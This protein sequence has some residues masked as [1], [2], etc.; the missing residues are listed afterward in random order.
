MKQILKY[1]LLLLF[2]ISNNLHSQFANNSYHDDNMMIFGFDKFANIITFTGDLDYLLN[3]KYG[4]IFLNQDY[5]GTSITNANSFRDDESLSFFYYYPIFSNLFANYELNWR[6][7][8]DTRSI[9]FN[10]LQRLNSLAGITYK[11]IPE[12]NLSALAGAESNTQ[13]GVNSNGIV[14]K[15][16]AEI[17]QYSFDNYQFNSKFAGEYLKLDDKRN[18][19]DIAF[20]FTAFR[21]FDITDNIAIDFNYKFLSRDFLI[22]N[23]SDINDFLVENRMET[24]IGGLFDISYKISDRLVAK[25]GLSAADLDVNRAYK[26]AILEES[27]TGVTRKLNE[28]QINLDAKLIYSADKLTQELN[29]KID[30]RTENN[31]IDNKWDVAESDL[32]RLRNSERQRDNIS[33]KNTFISKTLYSFNR[34]QSL[35]ADY[36]ISLLRYDTPSGDN[37]DDRDEFSTFGRLTY[38]QIYSPFL[39]MELNAELQAVHLVFLKS[40][41]SS[42]N[43]WNR[44]IK[45]SPV[46]YLNYKNFKM[47]P[48][49]EV[50]ANYTVFDFESISPNVNSFSFRQ[51]SYKDSMNYQITDRINIKSRFVFRY[52]ERGI[53]YWDSFRETPQSSNQE[54]LADILLV[55]KINENINIGLGVKYYNLNQ[56]NL[57]I[58]S[59]LVLDQRSIGPQV[60][61]SAHFLSGSQVTLSGWYEFQNSAGGGAR[62]IPNIFVNTAVKL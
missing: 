24:R 23:F 52:F 44:I 60:A 57:G 33:S 3:T 62:E 34:K 26:S 37:N 39:T 27:Q 43:N 10:E 45:F 9:G 36:Y 46:L 42:L 21:D 58:N 4:S 55:D 61:I 30:S 13:I 31:R 1:V 17:A 49:L 40:Q 11:P 47:E 25:V 53:L 6:L 7:N 14:Y 16:I 8:A 20:N 48:R 59:S 51:I 41:R 32:T 56:Q 29:F 38:R 22:S 12:I 54:L 5:S 50:L 35:R 28:L 2:L 15:G 19:S 18:N